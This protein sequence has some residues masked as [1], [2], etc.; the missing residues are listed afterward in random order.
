VVAAAAVTTVA[1]IVKTAVRATTITMAA[2]V[3]TAIK[4]SKRQEARGKRQEARSKR[5]E[6]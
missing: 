5:Q 1:V 4:R 2:A 6:V 3:D